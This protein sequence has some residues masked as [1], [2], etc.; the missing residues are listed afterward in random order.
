MLY[1]QERR[2]LIAERAA[3][4]AKDFARGAN[5]TDSPSFTSPSTVLGS[6]P[7]KC[8]WTRDNHTT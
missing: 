7:M 6:L 2:M 8:K 3:A 5:F 1:A 4:F